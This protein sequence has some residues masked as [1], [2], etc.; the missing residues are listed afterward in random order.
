MLRKFNEVEKDLE[1]L[2]LTVFVIHLIISGINCIPIPNGLIKLHTHTHTHSHTITHTW[3]LA[4][5]REN[6]LVP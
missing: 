2:N 4:C 5:R 1:K 6:Q 3:T